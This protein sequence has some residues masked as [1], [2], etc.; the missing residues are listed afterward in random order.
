M[1]SPWDAPPSAQRDSGAGPHAAGW[2]PAELCLAGRGAAPCQCLATRSWAEA[3]LAQVTAAGSAL[4][5]F[6]SMGCSQA[7]QVP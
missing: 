7:E 6:G 2:G 3:Q 4:S 1:A 5:R